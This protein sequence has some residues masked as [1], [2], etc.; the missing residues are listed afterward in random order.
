MK[1]KNNKQDQLKKALDS[2]YIRIWIN[3]G[4]QIRDDNLSSYAASC[5]FFIFL[6]LVPMLILL[7]SLLPFTPLREADLL[8]I[9][10]ENMPNTMGS[11]L[12][13]MI[14][15]AYG[16]SVGTLSF[17]AI[18]TLWSAG[19]GVNALINGLNAI[20]HVKSKRN[21]LVMRFFASLYTLI[22]LA[23]I[24]VLLVLFV[25]GNAAKDLLVGYFPKLSLIFSKLVLFRSVIMITL[26]T[27]VFMIL[28]SVLPSIKI[29]IRAQ[30]VGAFF[31]SVSWMAFSF[32]FSLYVENYGAFSMYGSFTT[33]IIMCFWLYFCIFLIFIGANINKYFRPVLLVFS[34][35]FADRNTYKGQKESL[36]D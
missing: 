11:M 22:F 33:I 14:S 21:G 35:R 24:L 30:F 20:E 10:Y 1:R 3:F 26:M 15:E 7:C 4:I 9:I 36:E 6:S 19:K 25:Y 16:K 2:K 8:S 13:S 32:L 29:R 18:T 34:K 5:A 23:S 17:A 28:Y 27:V 12:S 31:A